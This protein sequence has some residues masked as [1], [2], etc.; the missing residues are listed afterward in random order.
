MVDNYDSQI[1]EIAK[2]IFESKHV[3]ILTGAGVSTESGIPDFR[4][5]SGIW[6]EF[7]PLIYGNIE[8]MKKDPSAFWKMGK[9]IA[10]T[11]V[12]AKILGFLM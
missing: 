6:K 4:G 12:K 2:L 8:I 10:P 3:V 9:K 1:K 11:L 5:R 7:N